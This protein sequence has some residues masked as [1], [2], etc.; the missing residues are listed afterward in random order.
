M[1]RGSASPDI[2]WEDG[3]LGDTSV[4]FDEGTVSLDESIVDN[5]STDDTRELNA[6]KPCKHCGEP[7]YRE[8]GARGRAPSYHPECRPS[9]QRNTG[10]T[11]APRA[12]RVSKGEQLAA[13]QTEQILARLHRGLMKA[14]IMLAVVE[15]YD[16]AVIRINTPELLD[17]LRPVLVKYERFRMLFIG[18]E[19]GASVLGLVIVVCTTVLPIAAHHGLIP[20]KKAAQVLLNLPGFMLSMQQKMEQGNDDEATIQMMANA[21]E[22]AQRQR[23]RM[24][25]QGDYVDA[26]VNEG[27]A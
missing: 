16:A 27:V 9:A 12:V 19:G 2:S 3:S 6:G 23:T 4:I 17:N 18:V 24:N 21:Q 22:R 26:S 7:I 14:T 5:T 20:A 8:A 25:P 13:E 1:A 10:S 11:R 15:P